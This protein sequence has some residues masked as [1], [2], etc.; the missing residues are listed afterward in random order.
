[1]CIVLLAWTQRNF[2]SLV[3]LAY[4]IVFDRDLIT[5]I[6]KFCF[7]Y[8]HVGTEILLDGAGNMIVSPTF[9]EKVGA[10]YIAAFVLCVFA[11]FLHCF[12]LYIT[13]MSSVM[14][15]DDAFEPPIAQRSPSLIL[16]HRP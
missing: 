5:T 8:K 7:A 6:P 10:Y 3:P 12:C 2:N 13:M 15:I 16:S 1:M 9:V 14:I 11:T 4:R